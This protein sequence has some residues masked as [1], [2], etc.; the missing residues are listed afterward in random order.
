MWMAQRNSPGRKWENHCGTGVH[1]GVGMEMSAEGV[2]RCWAPGDEV[3]CCVG[4]KRAQLRPRES[5]PPLCISF[6]CRWTSLEPH[7]PLHCTSCLACGP[8]LQR[9]LVWHLLHSSPSLLP[10]ASTYFALLGLSQLFLAPLSLFAACGSTHSLSLN[11]SLSPPHTSCPESWRGHCEAGRHF[12]AL[13]SH[14][15]QP[16]CSSRDLA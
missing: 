7:P 14:H 12:C 8:S 15:P 9:A 11:A 4:L 6:T 10:T 2:F 5:C 16:G 1:I 3:F 13:H